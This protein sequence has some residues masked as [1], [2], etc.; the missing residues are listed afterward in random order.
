MLLNRASIL[1]KLRRLGEAREDLDR[2][3]R[4]VGNPDRSFLVKLGVT[5]E[6]FK[7]I[8]NQLNHYAY[9]MTPINVFR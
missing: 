2:A 4:E 9:L 6:N 5:A 7:F 1:M 8:F 3:S